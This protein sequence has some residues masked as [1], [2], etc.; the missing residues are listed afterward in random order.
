MDIF[1]ENAQDLVRIPGPHDKV[2]KDE[3]MYCFCDGQNDRGLF[4]NLFSF[5]SFCCDHLEL[6]REDGRRGTLY[7]V[8]KRC[9]K[10]SSDD[11]NAN[12]NSK[13]IIE[14]TET[15][16]KLAYD[17]SKHV[18]KD[19]IE[20]TYE[21]GIWLPGE[22]IHIVPYDES[23]APEMLRLA[24]V[25]IQSHDSASDEALA[26]V[27]EEERRV[28]KYAANLPLLPADRQIS[29]DASTWRCDFTGATENLWLNLSTGKIGSGRPH[30]DGTGGNGAALR[31][32]EETGKNYPLAVKLG[33]ITATSA[34]VYSYASDEDDMVI[35]PLLKEH[36]AHWGIDMTQMTKTEKTMAELQHEKNIMFE[37]DAITE[38]GSELEPIS[39][40]GF[41]GLKNL[42]N[43]CYMNSVLQTMWSIPE[44]KPWYVDNAKLIYSNSKNANPA[45]DLLCQVRFLGVGLGLVFSL[46]LQKKGL[47]FFFKKK[48]LRVLL[49][50]SHLLFRSII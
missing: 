11:D 49:R 18:L 35:D 25:G 13:D 43:S 26:D 32:F 21:I 8:V 39:G 2:Y 14:S 15:S 42:G 37:F 50:I 36:L 4:I 48:I 33:T 6:D 9:L 31:H 19:E 29:M 10:S 41:L 3:C 16:E 30:F 45:D 44:L 12:S 22:G 7:L 40:R 17:F 34:D 38:A 5:Q 1:S 24:V 46:F 20:E 27:W 28:S 47:W 23:L